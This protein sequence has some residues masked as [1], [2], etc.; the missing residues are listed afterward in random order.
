MKFQIDVE[1]MEVRR[2]SPRRD[3]LR[4]PFGVLFIYFLQW[5]SFESR[6]RACNL[7]I[8]RLELDV[9]D[10]N[11]G[12]G[13]E[14]WVERSNLSSSPTLSFCMHSGI[15]TR[16]STLTC[17]HGERGSVQVLV[18]QLAGADEWPMARGLL[19]ADAWYYALGFAQGRVLWRCLRLCYHSGWTYYILGARGGLHGRLGIV[20]NGDK[21]NTDLD[22]FIVQ[23]CGCA[24]TCV[25]RRRF[26]MMV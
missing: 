8:V 10:V 19:A 13:I 23:C 3:V 2:R 24:P 1:M 4:G 11:L 22:S 15:F 25:E 6:S 18:I 7:T 16:P 21:D 26:G 12:S 20:F 17:A 5:L 14:L 9:M